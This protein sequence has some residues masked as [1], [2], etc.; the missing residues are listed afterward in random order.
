VILATA[1]HTNRHKELRGT[2]E[3]FAIDTKDSNLY[4]TGSDAR[5]LAYG[6]LHISEAIGISPWYWFSDIPINQD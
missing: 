6:V 3:R 4:I 2:W 1:N 5:G